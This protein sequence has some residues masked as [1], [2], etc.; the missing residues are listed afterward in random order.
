[1]FELNGQNH[2]ELNTSKSFIWYY[3][4]SQDVNLFDRS[5]ELT[6]VGFAF[7]EKERALLRT[8]ARESQPRLLLQLTVCSEVGSR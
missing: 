1:M 7:Y 2:C 5:K 3:V 8:K 6:Q 4:D